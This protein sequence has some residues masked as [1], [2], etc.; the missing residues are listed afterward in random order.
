MLQNRLLALTLLASALAVMPTCVL[1]AQWVQT[2][3]PSGGDITALA[4][5]GSNIFTGTESN[6]VYRTT[7]NG[8]TWVSVNGGL[9]DTNIIALIALDTKL[10]VSAWSGYGYWGL[11]RSTDSGRTW[12]STDLSASYIQSLWTNG[13]VLLASGNDTLFRSIDQGL[14]WQADS[15]S[16]GL[17]ETTVNGFAAM[18]SII[19]AA[20][21]G[22]VF[23]SQDAG[24]TWMLSGMLASTNC[25]IMSGTSLFASTSYDG[26]FESSDTGKNWSQANTGLPIDTIVE[27]FAALGTTLFAGTNGGGIFMSSNNG[28]DWLR[29]ALVN[30]SVQTM[31]SLDSDL[32]VGTPNDIYLSKNLGASWTEVGSGLPNSNVIALGVGDTTVFAATGS[33]FF[34]SNNTGA[35]W[36][37]YDYYPVPIRAIATK[38]V[39]LFPGDSTITELRLGYDV[40]VVD[41]T[42]NEGPTIYDEVF[43]DF[44]VQ[45][46]VVDGAWLIAGTDS[47]G[48]FISS[49]FGNTWNSSGD[50]LDT[51]ITAL[52][53]I[54]TNLFVGIQGRG[55]LL[56]TDTGATWSVINTGL[57][58]TNVQALAA[59]GA[60]LFAGTP[61][62]GVF[63][64][65]NN[66]SNWESINT[67]LK[68]SDVLSLAVC[69]ADIF[70]GTYGSGVWRRPLSDFGISSVAQTPAPAS[71]EIQIYPNPFSQSTQITFTS[72]AAGYAE[73]SIVNMLGV[74]VARL[75]SGEVGA[76]EHNFVWNCRGALQCAPTDG[77]YE[78]LVRMNGQVETLPAVLMR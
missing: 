18:D 41:A 54:G 62:G 70:A 37:S 49:D 20:T 45:A 51:S 77:T 36:L 19:F 4:S 61:N 65:T 59:F 26:V 69:G 44:D 14:T 32:F 38:I 15:S 60:N 25:L 78:C 3:G 48:I 30:M 52:A 34:T 24:V 5:I 1:R 64:S 13:S 56:T 74:E 58:D 53:V 66:G 73:V 33:G 47:G 43:G 39:N 57:T 55:I 21:P 50:L 71:S 8:D 22:G 75:F 2:N 40:Y 9:P 12:D 27:G 23:L 35:S 11:F 68:D 10:F 7:N 6:G 28:K 42:S 67:G 16:D 46:L 31:L 17:P 76:G 63:L 72:Q 29:S